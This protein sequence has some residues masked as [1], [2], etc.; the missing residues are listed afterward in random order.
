LP[1]IDDNI[2]ST[3]RRIWIFA[4]VAKGHSSN[5]RL[6]IRKRRITAQGHD[7]T[8]NIGANPGRQSTDRQD[9]ICLCI[10]QCNR[11]TR[12]ICRINICN[13]YI[14]ISNGNRRTIF[15]KACNIVIASGCRIIR[16]QINHGKL[17]IVDDRSNP[18]RIAN[19]CIDSTGQYNIESLAR[20]G[21]HVIDDRH[22]DG[23]RGL[24]RRESQHAAGSRVIATGNR[25]AVAGSVIHS[26]R[27]RTFGTQ[28]DGKCRRACCF[29]HR[30]I[31]DAQRWRSIVIDNGCRTGSRGIAGVTR[32]N[33]RRQREGFICFVQGIIHNRH[34]NQHAGTSGR[35]RTVGCSG[36]ACTAIGG[37]LEGTGVIRPQ[38]CGAIAQAEPETGI[39]AADAR[40]RYRKDSVAAIFRNRNIAHRDCRCN[41]VIDDSPCACRRCDIGIDGIGE[42]DK[43]IL[44]ALIKHIVSDIDSDRLR[45]LARC[46]A[47]RTSRTGVVRS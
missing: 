1:I 5:R 9:I 18:G 46:K 21:Q 26:Y 47:Q 41:F 39:R 34:A 16:I 43:E 19:R 3:W 37:N 22:R 6:V 28:G 12:Q 27:L 25:T 32:S 29:I 35:Y 45:Q 42:V 20:L 7:I 36:P 4:G 14:H 17:V 40:L 31:I 11:G 33:V 30:H 44:V 13:R 10:G 2:D 38:C 24:S 8:D 23:L 15:S